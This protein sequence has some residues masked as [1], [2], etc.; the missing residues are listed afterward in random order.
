M[1]L[2]LF[3]WL[4]I[5]EFDTL[6]DLTEPVGVVQA[7]PMTLG[8]FDQLEDHGERGITG[9]ASSGLVGPQSDRRERALD[10]IGAADMLPM[11]GREVVEGEQDIAILDHATA[12]PSPPA[13][14]GVRSNGPAPPVSSFLSISHLP[15]RSIT[16]KRR[17]S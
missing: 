9:Q 7:A 4:S 11:L 15:C 1:I 12:G 8:R 2:G 14:W 5:S 13:L 10:G 3:D 6:D 16:A 17:L